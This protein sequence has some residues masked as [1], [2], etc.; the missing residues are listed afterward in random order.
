MCNIKQKSYT[1]QSDKK[2]YILR[3]W[4]VKVMNFTHCNDVVTETCSAI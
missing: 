2:F 4:K 3:Y 1:F